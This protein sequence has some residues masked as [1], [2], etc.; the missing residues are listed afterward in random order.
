MRIDIVPW[1]H[2]DMFLSYSM[3]A[4]PCICY[5]VLLTKFYLANSGAAI[6]ATGS[7]TISLI[8]GFGYIENP[9]GLD[10]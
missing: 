7:T 5:L 8:F 9:F 6:Q 1:V 3:M 4:T 10:I 2:I